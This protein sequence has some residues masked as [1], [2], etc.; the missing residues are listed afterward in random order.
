MLLPT[1][2]L[3]DISRH[4]LEAAACE[5]WERVHELEM[6]R[7]QLLVQYTAGSE[8]GLSKEYVE[9]SLREMLAINQ[10]VLELSLKARAE[11]QESL[12]TLHKGIKAGHAYR[13]NE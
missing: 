10:A 13:Q 11:L 12:G 8:T 6:L 3:L 9:G 1:D 5:D 4:M 2:K 7:S